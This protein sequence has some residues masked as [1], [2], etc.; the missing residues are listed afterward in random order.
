MSENNILWL[1]CYYTTCV[2]F[3]WSLFCTHQR[4]VG[5]ICG[6]LE[7]ILC[8]ELKCAKS[9]KLQAVVSWRWLRS[10]VWRAATVSEAMS[11]FLSLG[12]RGVTEAWK[13]KQMIL[14]K[15]R[16]R[17]NCK[18]TKLVFKMSNWVT[19]LPCGKSLHILSTC[20]SVPSGGGS[21][22]RTL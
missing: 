22:D 11:G 17:E 13:M 6:K 9:G 20:E 14:G 3:A 16:E 15:R 8:Q 19:N 21:N 4:A 5:F 1:H 18:N 12:E 10:A 2:I 7:T